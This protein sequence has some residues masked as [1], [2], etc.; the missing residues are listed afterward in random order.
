[1]R[2]LFIMKVMIKLSIVFCLCLA[3]TQAKPQ[4]KTYIKGDLKRVAQLGFSPVIEKQHLVVKRLAEDSNAS[5][6]GLKND[7]KILKINHKS[8]SK[9]PLNDQ[10]KLFKWHG[11]IPLSLIVERENKRHT[12]NFTPPKRALE[13]IDNVDSFYGSVSVKPNL[14]LR[15]IIA[16]PTKQREKSPKSNPAIFFVQW[17]SCGTIEY[18]AKSPSREILAQLI[19]RTNRALIRV[20][21]SADGDSQGPACHELD[22][23]TELQHYYEAFLQLRNNPLIDKNRIIIYGSSLGSTIA[24]LLAEKLK[25]KGISVEGI[26]IQGGGAVTYLER[27]LAFER[28]YMERRSKIDPKI[29]HQQMLNRIQFQV[30]YLGKGRHPDEIAKDSSAMKAVRDDILGMDKTTHYGRPF[31]WHQQA[32]Q[33]N[34][35]KAWK[36]AD[37]PVLVVYNEFD[38]FETEKGHRLI[39]DMI[40]RWKPNTATYVYKEKTGHGNYRYDNTEL[41]YRFAEGTNAIN[42]LVDSFVEWIDLLDKE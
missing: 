4:T 5:Q 40:N 23:D 18:R 15:S 35:L 16:L 14:K 41:A 32:A 29:I 42:G 26:M 7:D 39:V 9:N 11:D 24:P 22:Y 36:T 10:S 13:N 12:I 21:R 20:E 8:I 6:A 33:K 28:I 34:F 1:M 31:T 30:E 27:M 38:Q 25:E 17:V 37:V 19:K 3:Q 2:L